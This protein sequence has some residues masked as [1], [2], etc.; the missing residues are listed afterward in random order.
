MFDDSSIGAAEDVLQ[1]AMNY[2][3]CR[4]D[5][6]PDNLDRLE[7]MESLE[8]SCKDLV[9]S[10]GFAL[11]DYEIVDQIDGIEGQAA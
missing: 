6:H 9:R 2:R 11:R 4:D 5:L 3:P 8:R 10:L 1:A 7:F